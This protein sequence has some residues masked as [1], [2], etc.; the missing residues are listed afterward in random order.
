MS[1]SSY[2]EYRRA[3]ANRLANELILRLEINEGFG[4]A[5]FLSVD[6]CFTN[7]EAIRC[8]VN[9]QVKSGLDFNVSPYIQLEQRILRLLPRH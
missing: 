1:M 9:Q 6:N 3:L 2:Y 7:F 5:A 8:W 4:L